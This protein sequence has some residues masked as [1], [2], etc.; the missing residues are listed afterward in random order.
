[1]L[2]VLAHGPFLA[3]NTRSSQDVEFGGVYVWSE[4][5]GGSHGSSEGLSHVGLEEHL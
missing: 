4:I 1:M 2:N 3:A 5:V